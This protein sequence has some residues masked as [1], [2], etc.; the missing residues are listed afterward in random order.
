MNPLNGENTDAHNWIIDANIWIELR[1]RYPISI[2]KTLWEGLSKATLDG[3]IK[4]PDE[5]MSEIRIN[6]A[7]GWFEEWRELHNGELIHETD[8]VL[9]EKVISII[10]TFEGKLINPNSPQKN[11]GDPYIIALAIVNNANVVTTEKPAKQPN[12]HVKIPDICKHYDVPC[13]R[14]LDFLEV[15]IGQH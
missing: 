1:D 15:E 4:V 14:L 12:T 7:A 13:Y 5:V 6:D 2:F 8:E 10:Q 9:F 11:H 3:R